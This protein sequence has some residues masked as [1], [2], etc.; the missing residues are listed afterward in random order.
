MNIF[1]V[2]DL[3]TFMQPQKIAKTSSLLAV[4]IF[5]EKGRNGIGYFLFWKRLRYKIY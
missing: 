4:K 3:T 5:F 1:M 2:I